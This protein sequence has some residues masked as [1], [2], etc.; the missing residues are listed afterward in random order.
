MFHFLNKLPKILIIYANETKTVKDTPTIFS[1]CTPDGK[2]HFH[3]GHMDKEYRS[4]SI[5]L[6]KTVKLYMNYGEG[7]EGV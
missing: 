3:L 2:V 4:L 5:E 7:Y 6:E 1:H